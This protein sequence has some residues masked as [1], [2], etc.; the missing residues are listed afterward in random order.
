MSPFS[1]KPGITYSVSYKGSV[2]KSG[3][4][5]VKSK[6]NSSDAQAPDSNTTFRIGSVSK[7]FAVS[8]INF[9]IIEIAIFC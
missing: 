7:V 5:G 1:P 8:L 3:G 4:L 6:E 9:M 2:L